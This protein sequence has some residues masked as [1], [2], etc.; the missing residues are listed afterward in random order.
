MWLGGWTGGPCAPGAHWVCENKRPYFSFTKPNPNIALVLFP[1]IKKV[2]FSQVLHY[3][4]RL[5]C[6][7]GIRFV[8]AAQNIIF[9]GFPGPGLNPIPMSAAIPRG[10]ICDGIIIV[11]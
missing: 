8:V 4:D 11:C 3:P 6:G 5:Y 7:G 1:F 10:L 9:P 2:M